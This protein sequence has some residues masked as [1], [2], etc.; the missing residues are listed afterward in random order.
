MQRRQH[1]GAC[2]AVSEYGAPPWW[3]DTR[4]LVRPACRGTGATSGRPRPTF[5]GLVETCSAR[6]PPLLLGIFKRPSSFGSGALIEES[7]SG[8]AHE[9]QHSERFCRTVYDLIE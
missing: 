3:C 8:G 9:S 6:E 7:G 1:Q 4:L 5:E 2:G